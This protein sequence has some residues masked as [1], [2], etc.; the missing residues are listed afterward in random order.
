M[1]LSGFPNRVAEQVANA[2]PGPETAGGESN[3]KTRE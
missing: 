3:G 1:G 2:F